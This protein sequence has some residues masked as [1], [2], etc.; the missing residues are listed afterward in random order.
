[1]HHFHEAP[2]SVY[3][4]PVIVQFTLCCFFQKSHDGTQFLLCSGQQC[5]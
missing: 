4:H 2:S 1:M 5:A 3:V